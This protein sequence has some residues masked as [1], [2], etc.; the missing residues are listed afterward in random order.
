MSDKA[1]S[2]ASQDSKANHRQQSSS[3]AAL[4]SSSSSAAAAPSPSPTSA[5]SPLATSGPSPS[6]APHLV[7]SA[8][9]SSNLSGPRRHRS[10]DASSF[11]EEE[12]RDV[13]DVPDG[14]DFK[15]IGRIKE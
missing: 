1:S 14:L 10:S 9:I 5:S 15:P 4:S 13:V 2:G 12:A 3:G 6:G 11:D 8:S 7:S